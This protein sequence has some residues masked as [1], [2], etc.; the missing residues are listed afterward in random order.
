MSRAYHTPLDRR[1]NLDPRSLQ[2]QGDNMLA[3]ADGL[4]RAAPAQLKSGGLIYL[5]ILGRWLPRLPSHWALPLSI[6]AFAV[7]AIA[8][9]LTPRE[10]ARLAQARAGGADAIADAGGRGRHG[11][12]AARP[13]GVDFRP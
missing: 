11:L 3:M 6:L 4:R 7:I 10:R 5:D 9:L 2:Q 13:G 8:G 1:E 12:C